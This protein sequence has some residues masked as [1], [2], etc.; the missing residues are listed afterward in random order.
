MAP[1]LPQTEIAIVEMTNAFRKASA[2][3]E[4]KPSPVL[5]AA[6]RAFAQYLAKSGKFGHEADGRAPDK[7]AQAEGYQACMVAENLAWNADSRGFQTKQL[8]GEI[9]EGWKDSPPHRENLLLPEATEIGVAVVPAPYKIQKFIAVQL[10]GRP[11]SEKIRF[12]IRNTTRVQVRYSVGEE[13]DT[14]EPSASVNYGVCDL[15]NLVFERGGAPIRLTPRDGD[16]FVIRAAKER[17][18]EVDVIAK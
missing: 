3:Q 6:A 8:A 13:T 17:A 18:F 10:F 7:R 9:V 16:R 1:D 5:A 11:E 15:P 4:V 12:A 14:I 2:L